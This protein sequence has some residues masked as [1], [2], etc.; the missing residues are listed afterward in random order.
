[1]LVYFQGYNYQCIICETLYFPKEWQVCCHLL[2]HHTGIQHQCQLCYQIYLRNTITHGCNAR[3]SDFEP[4]H[5]ESGEKGDAARKR[6]EYIIVN[7]MDQKWR[8]V[9]G[10]DMEADSPDHLVKSKMT[11]IEKACHTDTRIEK[12]CHMVTRIEK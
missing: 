10:D 2:E 9:P 8:F 1:M 5:V 11:R 12:G 4:M 6:L 3:A 7:V